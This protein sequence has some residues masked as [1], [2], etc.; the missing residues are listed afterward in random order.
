MDLPT[1]RSGAL[2]GILIGFVIAW[3]SANALAGPPLISDDPNTIGPGNVQPIVSV[4]VF[5]AEDVTTVRAPLVDLTVGLVESLD[6]TLIAAVVHTRDGSVEPPWADRASIFPGLK[7]EFFITDRGSLAFS[8]AFNVNTSSPRRSFA[9]L[10]FQGELSVGRRR[11]ATVGFDAGYE[12]VVDSSHRWFVAPYAR[13]AAS[14]K[15]HA[16]F[17]LWLLAEAFVDTVSLGGSVGIDYGIVGDAVRL[18]A[19]LSPG[20]ATFDGPRVDVR[21]YLGVQYI[22]SPR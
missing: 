5:Q 12:L 1:K 3:P 19:A 8:P 22:F 20:F 21:A 18:I 6:M 11:R 2:A 15:I 9:L 13:Y 17:E 4:S 10:P 16:L 7:W 14:P